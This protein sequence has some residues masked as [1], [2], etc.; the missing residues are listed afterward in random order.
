MYSFV[1]TYMRRIGT[2]TGVGR[3]DSVFGIWLATCWAC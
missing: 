1:M 2:I 3:K